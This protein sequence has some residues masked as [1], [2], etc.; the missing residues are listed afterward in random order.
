MAQQRRLADVAWD[1]DGKTLVWLEG[2]SDR[3]VLIASTAGGPSRDLTETHSVRALVGYGGGDFTAAHG[4]AYYAEQSSGRL[5]RLALDC[6][7]PRAVTP[8]F[9][10]AA[11]PR[12]SPDGRWLAYVHSSE[13]LDTI[14]LTDTAG[15]AWPRKFA[16]GAD[17]YM[18]PAWS[19]DSSRLA[20]I[21]WDHPNMPWDATRLVIGRLGG[22]AAG[23]LPRLAAAEVVREAP[24][25]A[26]ADPQFTPDG[27]SLLHL[28]DES[29]WWNLHRLDLATGKSIPLAPDDAETGGPSWNQGQR[30]YSLA[31]DGW[32]YYLRFKDGYTTLRRVRLSGGRPEEVLVPAEYGHL[33]FPA[34]A[35]GNGEIALQ[36]SGP[37]VPPRIVTLASSGRC[38]V[39]AH[40]APERVAPAEL[41][42]PEPVSWTS[43]DG[44]PAH[45]L[46]YPPTNP[47]FEA[48]GPPPLVVSVHGGPTSHRDARYEPTAQFLATRG[49]AVLEVNHRGS[50]GYGRDYLRKL[51]GQWG[52]V[53]VEDSVGGARF[54][55]D[56]GRADSGRLAIMGGSAGGYTVLL[57][58]IAHPGFFRA[59]VNLFG[60]SD[61]F[62]LAAETHKFEERYTDSMVGPLPEAAA[63]YRERSAVFH[64]DK[65]VDPLA[66]FQG[67]EDKV[68][69]KAQSDVIVESLRRRGVPHEYHLYEGEGHGWR[70]VE[71][72]ERYYAALEAFLRRWLVYS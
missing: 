3:G 40:A 29:G 27:S 15:R 42:R 71:T 2:R 64:A 16:E 26:F 21:E 36:A 51:R 63:L 17:F 46:Y 28:S 18:Q 13:G 8:A 30:Y 58:L 57:A 39:R 20:W 59:G 70:K 31:P 37:G 6:G 43:P 60:V 67:A 34:V 14:A 25:T 65:I 69:P 62:G 35:P 24:D 12:V 4:H 11:S 56:A 66:V 19:P 53:D 49:Y 32:V 55:A 44:G 9:G 33:S 38:S 5:Y 68:V 50:T 54:L 10:Q 47:G 72:I 7:P 61:L 23:E 52:V 1:S 48:D 41:A 45:G 22:G